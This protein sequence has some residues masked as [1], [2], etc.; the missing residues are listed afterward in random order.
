MRMAE[1]KESRRGFIRAAGAVVF[2]ATAGSAAGAGPSASYPPAP[3]P[4]DLDVRQFGAKGDGTTIDTRAIN[5]AIDAAAEAGGGTVH[6]PAGNYLSYSIHLKSNV[7]LFLASGST[8]L[9]ADPPKNGEAGYDLAESNKPWEDYQDF[10]HNHWHNSLIWGEDL[11]NVSICGPGLIWGKG[12]SRGE[13]EGPVAEKPG[14]GNKAI[15]L[16][17]CRD[18][19]LRDFSILHGGHFGILATGVDNLTIDNLKIDT[20]RDGM[21]VDCCR[22][23]R[24]SNCSVNS[25]WDDA[26]CLKS[27]FALGYARATEMVTISDCMVSGNF[28]EG[29]LLNATFK[30]FPPNA[31]I[32][33]NGRIKFGTESNGGYKNITISN[34]VF[35]GCFGLTI[36]S[37]DGALIEDV[38]ISNITMRDTV[39]SPIFLRLGAR[40]RGPAGVPI[41]RI[42]RVN[43][44][45]IVS[46][47]S[48]GKICSMIVGLPDHPIEDVKISNILIQHP[49]GG[50]K[51][52]AAI[53]LEEK[54]KDYPEPT[55]FGTTPAHGLLIRHAKGIEISDLKVIAQEADARPCI[56]VDDAAN[57]DFFRI[58]AEHQPN[59][60]V[61]V[62]NDVKDFTAAKCDSIPDAQIGETKHKEL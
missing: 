24:I 45:N 34:C 32:D 15:A 42:R 54:P 62:L 3:G 48:S 18:V 16:K 43:I 52:D 46:L 31:N 40:M 4:A 12:L 6:F 17:N 58:K 33:R 29:T 19:L 51:Q 55:M 27:S 28:Q 47:N 20:N 23:V 50:T 26:I 30:P 10:G 25:P 61:F 8:I 35:D 7:R 57:V 2:G 22:N 38:S 11:H 5:K 9:A 44:S 60:S 13:G 14:V 41:G 53:H 49:G 1:A 36:L 59:T 56:E 39:A 21:D 37:V